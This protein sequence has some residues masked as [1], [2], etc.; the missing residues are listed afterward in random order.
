MK[1]TPTH[2][3]RTAKRLMPVKM[4]CAESALPTGMVQILRRTRTAWVPKGKLITTAQAFAER[5]G[6]K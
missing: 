1:I 2:Y 3:E 6:R 4:I 5:A